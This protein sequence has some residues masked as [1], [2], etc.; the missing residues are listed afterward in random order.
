MKR[1]KRNFTLIEL[2]VVIAIIAILAGMLLPALNQARE[3]A[4]KTACTNQLKTLANY[5]QMY[6]AGFQDF[7]PCMGGNAENYNWATYDTVN[8]RISGIPYMLGYGW[9]TYGA[10]TVKSQS[11]L[12]R[13]PAQQYVGLGQ[14]SN[15][16]KWK[17]DYFGRL[18][19]GWNREY[20]S[21]YQ[22]KCFRITN[23]KKTSRIFYLIETRYLETGNTHYPWEAIENA[24]AW[25]YIY[26]QRH[27][28]VG[29][30][31]FFDGHVS[32][33][34]GTDPAKSQAALWKD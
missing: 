31:A 27:N 18:C 24:R 21:G 15:V 28:K 5:T 29:N 1:D 17:E 7:I 19:Y 2:L 11:S 30:L 33:W 26:G 22:G 10:G 25:S 20:N 9:N 6:C 34:K 32:S 14:A 13:C 8:N 12:Y 23:I 3:T 4:K 16:P